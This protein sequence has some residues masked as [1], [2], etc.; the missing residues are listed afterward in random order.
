MVMVLRRHD[1]AS[2]L[3]SLHL[4]RLDWIEAA[5]GLQNAPV[6]SNTLSE[7]RKTARRPTVLRGSQARAVASHRR[8]YSCRFAWSGCITR[9]FEFVLAAIFGS[10]LRRLACS[11]QAVRIRRLHTP[12][13]HPGWDKRWRPDTGKFE[14]RLPWNLPAIGEPRVMRRLAEPRC[15]RD[16]VGGG[17]QGSRSWAWPRRPR[18]RLRQLKVRPG[19]MSGRSS[20]KERRPRSIDHLSRLCLGAELKYEKGAVPGR[21]HRGFSPLTQRGA[22]PPSVPYVV[23]PR[24]P[25]FGGIARRR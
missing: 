13:R 12:A 10:R 25:R 18:T 20:T 17:I 14:M 23:T 21:D 3:R 11:C 22:L 6:G 24:D 8:A 16:G 1:L 15:V 2:R 5:I 4:P 7:G 19:K 9:A